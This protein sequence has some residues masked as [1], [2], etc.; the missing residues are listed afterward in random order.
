[1]VK[2]FFLNVFALV[3]L[4]TALFTACRGNNNNVI[5]PPPTAPAAV[6][7]LATGGTGTSGSGGS[8][9]YVYIESYGTVT[10]RKSGTVD[11]SFTIP[12]FTPDFGSIS[13][14]VSGGITTVLLDTDKN[15]GSPHLYVKSGGGDPNLY[16]GNGDGD[17]TNDLPVTGLTVD[18]GA[19]LVLVDQGY[20]GG[21]GTV[22]LS[23]DLVV[24]G[25]ITSDAPSIYIEANV[26]DVESSGKITT[27]ATTPD[28]PAGEIYL[29]D[30]NSI[31]KTI[32]NRGT[33]EAKG[34]GT[35]NGGYTYF[36]ADDL[37]VNYGT[38]DTSG[39]ASD[40]GTG[41]SGGEFDV[42]VDYGNFYSSG[43]VRTNGGGAG[44]D[45]N[46]GGGA[47]PIYIYTAYYDNPTSNG[48]IIIS[49]TW[50]ANGG[51][52]T[53]TIAN[54]TRGDGGIGG[55]IYFETDAMGAVTVNAT[56]S[57]KGGNGKG[58]S[59]TGGNA[60]GIE[61]DSYNYYSDPAIPG[62]ITISGHYD[63]RGGGGDEN[64]GNGG[65]LYVYNDT[66]TYSDNLGSDVELVNFPATNLNGGEGGPTGGSAASQAFE[67]D[68]YSSSNLSRSITNE[69]NIEAI[70]GRARD[71]GGTGGNGGNITTSP[72][73]P[74]TLN[75]GKLSVAGGS[76][77][78]PGAP[79]S[80]TLN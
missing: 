79:G 77:T 56:M 29:G 68:T 47:G 55:Y 33:I 65:Y 13:V 53:G 44:G 75:T 11:A 62:K 63:L 54:V 3:F 48:D 24:N 40:T 71:A 66:T 67:I 28:S 60:D 73:D 37:V 7:L 17:T 38:I 39:G 64:G 32:I 21:Y 18:A 50:E 52:G 10:V 43:T 12:A 8:G 59:S 14:I 23:N 76:G 26:I 9:G 58:A 61:I 42:Y 70:G 72:D 57:T 34:L 15:D 51:D 22:W 2:N 4:S 78:N 31:T 16:L 25:T 30:G 27:S 35:G 19:T 45:G 20:W 74:P 6:V 41:G 69:A 36:E 49:G 46:S 1:M 80:I 5:I